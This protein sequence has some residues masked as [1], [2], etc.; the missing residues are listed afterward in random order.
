MWGCF[1]QLVTATPLPT[2][3]FVITVKTDNNGTSSV[4]QFTIPTYPGATYNYDVACE[5]DGGPY[6]AT[7]IT[8]D[9]TCTYSSPG[10]HMIAIH[11]MFPRIFFNN[12]GDKEKLLSIN[13]WGDIGWSSMEKSFYGCSNLQIEPEA[14]H[15]NLSRVTSMAYMFSGASSL[16]EDISSWDVSGVTDFNRMF[17]F[18]SDF[19]QSLNGW[20]VSN[21]VDMGGIFQSA[22]TFNGNITDWNISKVESMAYMFDAAYAFNQPIGNW[23]VSAVWDMRGVFRSASAFNQSLG[24][25]NVSNVTTMYNMFSGA[26]LFN[27]DIGDWNISS[28]TEMYGMFSGLTSSFNQDIGDWNVTGVTNMASMFS[29]HALSISQYDSLLERWSK[30]ALTLY[31]SFSAGNSQYCQGENGRNI[32]IGTYDWNIDDM[33]K[34]CDFYITTPDHVTVESGKASVETAAVNTGTPTYS[35]IGGADGDLF[36]IDSF[37]G[38]LAFLST[39][40][41]HHP[42]DRNRDNVYRVQVQADNGGGMTDIQTVRVEVTKANYGTLPPVIMYLL[43]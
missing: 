8:G 41:F 6:G 24:N 31:V 18:A 43:N 1:I 9:Y 22:T 27:Q 28:V 33:G 5:T 12:A 16:N 23:D 35:I 11:G 14:G 2:G 4:N 3:A 30:E 36:T 10:Q 34:N 40:Y 39:P 21:A 15:P 25:W 20:D 32:L 42:L 19:N 17:Q 7:G 38:A 29:G 26:A 13:Q 37:S